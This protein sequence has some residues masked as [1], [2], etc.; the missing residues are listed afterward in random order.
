MYL[1]NVQQISGG[2]SFA[3]LYAQDA[4]LEYAQ[5][6]P[7][8]TFGRA[9]GD[10]MRRR[11]F[12]AS[13]RPPVRFIDDEELA[14]VAQRAREVHDLWHVLFN[15]RTTVLGELALKAVEFMQVGRGPLRHHLQ[16]RRPC[17]TQYMDSEHGMLRHSTSRCNACA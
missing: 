14:Y 4:T 8:G 16:C 9:Y 2:A 11:S 5:S 3:V 6:L 12:L 10:F 7:E 13:D 15:C 17:A 1:Q